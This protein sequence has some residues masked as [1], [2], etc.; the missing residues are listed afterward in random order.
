MPLVGLAIMLGGAI[1]ALV[2][3]GDDGWVV[4]IL[5]FFVVLMGF[6]F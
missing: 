3:A 5:G 2:G 6:G 1:A 4:A